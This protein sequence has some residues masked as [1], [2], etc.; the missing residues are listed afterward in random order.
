MSLQETIDNADGR[1]IA[2][3][4]DEKTLRFVGQEVKRQF[5]EDMGSMTDWADLIDKGG[6][7]IKQDFRPKSEPFDGASNYK[8]PVIPEAVIKFGDK[9]TLELL[10]N[11]E[12]VKGTII[13][14]DDAQKTK[15]KRIERVMGYQN[16]ELN[17]KMTEWKPDQEALFY[18]LPLVGNLFKKTAFDPTKGRNVSHT[19]HYP[20]FAVNQSTTSIEEA[21]SF[22]E[23]LAF[24]K[25]EVI[26]RQRAGIWLDAEL[27]GTK[28]T[29]SAEESESADAGSNEAED[30]DD[31]M[32]NE[33]RFLAQHGF[34]DLD[35]DG[36]AEPY[37]ITI[38]E[39][40]MTI[41][42]IV[43]RYT[44]DTITVKHLTRVESLTDA[45]NRQ[46]EAHE[47]FGNSA[48]PFEMDLSDLELVS[49][50]AESQI[51]SYPF[52]PALD[53]TFLGWGYFHL[54]A[55]LLIANNMTTNILTDAGQIEN[56]GGGWLAK[57]ARKKMG[58]MR[59]KLGQWDSTEFS[60]ADL[61]NGILPYPSSAPSQSLMVLNEKLEL[62]MR[63]F[64]LVA[65]EDSK[66]QANTAPTTAL[67]ILEEAELP[68]SAL[69]LRVV[70]AESSEFNK[71]FRLNRLFIDPA[72]YQEVLDDPEADAV[73]DFNF[74]DMD[75]KPTAN[76]RI[77]S[78]TKQIQL[79]TAELEQ[80]DRVLAAGGNPLPILENYFEVLG[81]QLGERIFPEEGSL[82]EQEKQQL[83][84]MQQA[85]EQ[86]NELA[87]A[88]LEQTQ[89]QTQLLT[90]E[91]ERLEAET[92]S[93]NEKREA[94]TG[95][96][97]AEAED[98][99]VQT[100][101]FINTAQADLDQMK[102]D[103]ILTLEKAE[104]E[105]VKNQISVY[106]ARFNTIL[107]TIDQ[108]RGDNE[109]ARTTNGQVLAGN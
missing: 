75:I 39:Q 20:N 97:T 33:Q 63:N 62:Q 102:A 71:L 67:A 103:I 48:I 59:R 40:S 81:S 53:G 22:T 34:A 61:A 85:Q 38:H 8:S 57:G 77:S 72:E 16:Y 105:D 13:G 32:D 98:Q 100:L 95:K 90:R 55:N 64:T 106:T 107:S 44:P 86:A 69:L 96:I 60:P 84:A 94:E 30:V 47:Q 74:Q 99:R 11:D 24:S 82:T 7:A 49:I 92:L 19:I 87:S 91:L 17:Y 50:G 76:P 14:K 104:S 88:Q 4:L 26:E 10:G 70:E 54:I 18:R 35:D 25:N 89:L 66:L 43:A 5:D 41:V 46:A 93:E 6:E 27:F 65:G 79:A 68:T 108:L 45:V 28:T 29:D 51:T 101:H 42:S 21:R 58:P 52:Y 56:L 37:I 15:K 3:D 80:F 12:I 36:Y 9:A 23:I 1:N 109:R 31:A 73:A 78:K 2:E 83:Q